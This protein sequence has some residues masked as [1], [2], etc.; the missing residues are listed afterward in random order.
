[1]MVVPVI[2]LK[3]GLAVRGVGGRR[4]A[5]RPVQS[6]LSS[7]PAPEAIGRAFKE[8][9][10]F[11]RVYLADLDAIAGGEPSWGVYRSLGELGLRLWIDAGV[12]DVQRATALATVGNTPH[13]APAATTCSRLMADPAGSPGGCEKVV[14]G[15]ETLP[16]ADALAEIV[17]HLGS[18]RVIFSL[19]LK[20]GQPLAGPLWHGGSPLEIARHAVDAGV[21][22][23]LVLD[24]A[25]VGM[26][27]GAITLEL[28]RQLKRLGRQLGAALELIGGGGVRNKDDL[29]LLAGA[30]CSAA[31]VASAL[32][33]GRLGASE[34][35][36]LAAGM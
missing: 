15:L 6:V 9:L 22:S 1:M 2:D 28:C 21:R 27:R 7:S 23:I 20:D 34:V 13:E 33:D 12:S 36:E 35:H 29:L 25:A 11:S 24:L 31:L 32:H 5:Y 16:S 4:E 17:A 19:D 18:Q 3:A 14:V 30:G 10:G 26:N 8:R